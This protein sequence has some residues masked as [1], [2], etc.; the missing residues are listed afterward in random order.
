MFLPLYLA[1]TPSEIGV[2][3]AL[4]PKIGW[5][6]CHFS[7]A[8]RGLSNLPTALP[9][10][11]MVVLDDWIE[12]ADHDSQRIQEELEKVVSTFD[13]SGVLLDFQRMGTPEVANLCQQLTEHLPCPVGVPEEYAKDLSCPVFLSLP[14]LHTPLKDYINPWHDREIWL[15]AAIGAEIATITE[16]GCSLESDEL[17]TLPEPWHK[18]TA[19]HCRYH[20]RQED[21]RVKFLLHRA[22]EDLQELLEEA[23]SLGVTRAIG[24]YQQL[25]T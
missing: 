6:A 8:H 5:L 22:K 2:A 20:W 21:D 13:C 25:H 23:G 18:D 1:M 3:S 11:S 19:L 12:F 4:P 24:L 16:D 10:G 14:D 17:E 15:E 7:G 9:A